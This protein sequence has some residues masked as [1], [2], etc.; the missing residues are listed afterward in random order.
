MILG[1]IS[2]NVVAGGPIEDPKQEAS[3]ENINKNATISDIDVHS[4][5][6]RSTDGCYSSEFQCS[7]GICIH[8]TYEC[9]GENDCGDYSDEK[10]CGGKV[11]DS[12]TSWRNCPFGYCD[13]S[14]YRCAAGCEDKEISHT[15]NN[16]KANGWCNDV[17]MAVKCP[18]TCGK[19]D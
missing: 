18:R 6:K 3:S 16:L 4:R 9:D 15:C 7:N 17:G 8:A 12:C 14:T 11:G 5:R 19:C 13:Y 10:N 2:I 1:M